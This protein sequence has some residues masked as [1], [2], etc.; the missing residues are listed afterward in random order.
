[1]IGLWDLEIEFETGT[2]EEMLKISRW[3]RT[4]FKDII[5][6][7]EVIPLFHEYKYNFFPGNLLK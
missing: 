3:I 5:K 4:S 2:R 7:F 6:E 1:M